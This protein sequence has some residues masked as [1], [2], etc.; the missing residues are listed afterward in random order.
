MGLLGRIFS[1]MSDLQTEPLPPGIA[2]ER[3]CSRQILKHARTAHEQIFRQIQTQPTLRGRPRLSNPEGPALCPTCSEPR[4]ADPAPA[5]RTRRPY[6]P[7]VPS[8][9]LPGAHLSSLGGTA[10]DYDAR[11]PSVPD[12]DVDGR[13]DW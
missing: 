11:S 13:F 6:W 7:G 8:P 10:G 5:G 9:R 2:E 12:S 3:A 1:R 4:T